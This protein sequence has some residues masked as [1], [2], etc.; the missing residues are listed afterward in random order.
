[1]TLMNLRFQFSERTTLNMWFR[2]RLGSGCMYLCSQVSN[3][4]G[5][6][7]QNAHLIAISEF[8]PVLWWRAHTRAR[9][10]FPTFR[11]LRAVFLIF[12]QLH[13]TKKDN[14]GHEFNMQ[15]N[16]F[17]VEKKINFRLSFLSLRQFWL[18]VVATV[19][20]PLVH[21]I[22]TERTLQHLENMANVEVQQNEII[23]EIE[24]IKSIQP[25]AIGR[26][27]ARR[28]LVPPIG[29]DWIQWTRIE[30]L[31]LLLSNWQW[32]NNRTGLNLNA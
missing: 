16:R 3:V 32:R 27:F 23:V 4:C 29:C 18:G 20:N 12:V 17:Y 31:L 1:M 2:W 7:R 24:P 26:S 19:Q 11:F 10:Q 5:R 22:Q 28:W 25:P 15:P 9:K 13:N 6:W 14:R 8:V 21:S 30:Q